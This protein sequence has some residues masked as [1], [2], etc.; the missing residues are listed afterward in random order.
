MK[1]AIFASIAL[2]LVLVTDATRV[3]DAAGFVGTATAATARDLSM[4]VVV[5]HVEPAP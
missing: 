1:A 2:A 5:L 4:P 3:V